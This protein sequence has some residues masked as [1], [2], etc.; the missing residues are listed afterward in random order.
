MMAWRKTRTLQAAARALLVRISDLI[1][2]ATAFPSMLSGKIPA[3]DTS[4]RFRNSSL[5]SKSSSGASLLW[6]SWIWSR[7]G[8]GKLPDTDTP[9]TCP[10]LV[11]GSL[12]GQHGVTLATVS[13]LPTISVEF[14]VDPSARVLSPYPTLKIPLNK[15]NHA[16]TRWHEGRFPI[17]RDET[18][19]P[20]NTRSTSMR[21][22]PAFSPLG[23]YGVYEASVVLQGPCPLA[24]GLQST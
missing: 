10:Y 8:R 16:V 13:P 6:N 11:C 19:Q 2:P 17:P 21:S 7:A 3:K 12:F 24:G 15:A 4:H 1:K 22:Y 14:S 20:E 23:Q 9:K 18:F 5:V